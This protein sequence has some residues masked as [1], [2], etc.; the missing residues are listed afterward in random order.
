PPSVVVNASYPGAKPKVIAETVARPL[1]EQMSG[2]ENML[3][4][5]SKAT[6]DRRITLTVTFK[7]GTDPDL[8]QQMVQNR[9]SQALPRLPEV[10]RLTDVQAVTCSPDLPMLVQLI[11]TDKS[12]DELYLRNYAV[13]NIKDELAKVSGVGTVRLFGSG[14]YAMRIWLNPE[15]IAERHLTAND[16]VNA[17]REQNV[18]VAAGIIGGAPIS[19]AV[20]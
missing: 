5:F 1:E 18:Q 17:V 15:K 4:M 10:T 7:I 3:Y 19:N 2:V 12:Y 14:D 16:V 13:M 20:E 8:P 6:T 11:A 9:V